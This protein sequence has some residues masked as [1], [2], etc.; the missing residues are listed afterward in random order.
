MSCKLTISKCR[1]NLQGLFSLEISQ[2][3]RADLP[4]NRKKVPLQRHPDFAKAVH[5]DR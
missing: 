4:E 1:E 2:A 3:V 5:F